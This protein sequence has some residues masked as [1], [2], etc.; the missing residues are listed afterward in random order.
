MNLFEMTK[1]DGNFEAKLGHIYFVYCS[2]ISW[3][4]ARSAPVDRGHI[5]RVS[6][7]SD[8]IFLQEKIRVPLLKELKYVDY[9]DL[10]ISK[11]LVV[12]LL[13][14]SGRNTEKGKMW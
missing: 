14:V 13:H 2:Y 5:I 9:V 11:D 12:S 1:N 4:L 8:A 3:G 6:T 7:I 10:R